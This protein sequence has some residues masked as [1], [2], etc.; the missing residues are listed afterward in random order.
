M[1]RYRCL[2]VCVCVCVCVFENLQGESVKRGQ[3]RRGGQGRAGAGAW[4]PTA[5]KTVRPQRTCG[6]SRQSRRKMGVCCV[7]EA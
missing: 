4:R 1:W 2:C 6:G 5:G 3:E 7:W